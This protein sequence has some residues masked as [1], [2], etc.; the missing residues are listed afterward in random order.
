MANK[1]PVDRAQHR[2]TQH[3]VTSYKEFED[4]LDFTGIQFPVQL[5]DITKFEQLNSLHSVNVF[6]ISD[7]RVVLPGADKPSLTIIPLRITKVKKQH[8]A[9]LLYIQNDTG[10]SHYVLIKDKS[11][12]LGSQLTKHDGKNNICDYCLNNFS[13]ADR[14][15]RHVELCKQKRC[16]VTLMP[17]E[18]KNMLSFNNFRQMF[19]L[20][21]FI[22]A[23]AE[24]LN[25]KLPTDPLD[26][27]TSSTTKC[28]RL[29]P[30]SIGYKVV[31]I[32]EGFHAPPKR[33][34][35]PECVEEFL[36]SLSAD[37]R[38]LKKILEN[39]LEMNLTNEEEEHFQTATVCHICEKPL[40]PEKPSFVRDHCHL[41]GKF[42]GASHSECNLLYG[43]ANVKKHKI[44]VLFHNLAGFD[45]N[46]IMSAVKPRKHGKLE[47]L[48]RTNHVL[49]HSQLEALNLRIATRFLESPWTS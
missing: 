42:R 48:P 11:R 25:V 22:V 24:T 40:S 35:G 4:E 3:R 36:N 1:H 43:L 46:L 27:T 26:L 38:A 21:F 9:D 49:S 10:N 41:T 29:P 13:S 33:F 6:G 32:D 37:I 30:C 12:L 20:P 45:S 23:D 47:E 28:A 19:P 5:K 18:G 8:H 31:C 39:R 44:P 2:V 17:Q 14:L 15:I 34:T 7:E 16:Q